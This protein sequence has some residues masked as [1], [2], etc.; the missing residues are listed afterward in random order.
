M[1][2]VTVYRQFADR[3]A[4][5]IDTSLFIFDR[6]WQAIAGELSDIDNPVE[7]M[8]EALLINRKM[9]DKDRAEGRYRQRDVRIEGMAIALSPPGL[10]S[11]TV[12]LAPLL[13]SRPGALAEGVTVEDLA[14]WLH[15][16]SFVIDSQ[17]SQ[18]L[19]TDGQWRR[20]LEP[21]IRGGFLRT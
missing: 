13:A 5:F 9:I 20:W 12:H 17:V 6:R 19:K 4:L 3:S 1:A 10:T 2:R 8:V 7:W 15:W 18:R 16:Q 11:I 21:Q 14:E